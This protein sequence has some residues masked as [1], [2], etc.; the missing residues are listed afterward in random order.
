MFILD[1]GRYLTEMIAYSDINERSGMALCHLAHPVAQGD[2]AAHHGG[3][4]AQ[5]GG[6]HAVGDAGVD[7]DVVAGEVAGF[8]TLQ[9]IL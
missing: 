2:A 4:E 8:F 6:G 7:V 1:A 9:S 3:H 5:S